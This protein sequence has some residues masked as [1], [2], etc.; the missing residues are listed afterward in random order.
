MNNLEVIDITSL[1]GT[2]YAYLPYTGFILNKQLLQSDSRRS[3]EYQKLEEKYKRCYSCSGGKSNP[4]IAQVDQ[5]IEIA[6]NSNCKDLILIGGDLLQNKSPLSHILD[7]VQN[8]M[9]TTVIAKRLR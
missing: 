6:K 3:I 5:M 4:S 7:I 1:S 2:E 9:S 8:D